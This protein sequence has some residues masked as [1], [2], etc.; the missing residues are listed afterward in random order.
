MPGEELCVL[1][2]HIGGRG[3]TIG[4]NANLNVTNGSITE[5]P[6]LEQHVLQRVD[7]SPLHFTP[8]K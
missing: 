3:S 5:I 2:H 6:P 4:L 8:D 1:K 7:V